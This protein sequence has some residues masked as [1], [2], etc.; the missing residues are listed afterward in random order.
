MT[1]NKKGDFLKSSLMLV[2]IFMTTTMIAQPS[3]AKPKILSKVKAET[4]TELMING[5]WR[6]P[7]TGL[8]WMRCSLGQTW[9]KKN[10]SCAGY[11]SSYV[12]ASDADAAANRLIFSGHD[13]WRLP[14]IIELS[15]V[16]KCPLGVVDDNSVNPINVSGITIYRSCKDY[17]WLDSKDYKAALDRSVFLDNDFSKLNEGFK[18]WYWSSSDNSVSADINANSVFAMHISGPIDWME[19]IGSRTI[20]IALVVRDG[21]A[22]ALDRM[23]SKEIEQSLNESNS[24]ARTV[25]NGFYVGQVRQTRPRGS[26]GMIDKYIVRSINEENQR[27]TIE[28]V[29]GTQGYSIDYKEIKEKLCSDVNDW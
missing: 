27:V 12:S 1:I 16:R 24:R 4:D 17:G 15:S 8:I 9:D 20:N 6:N 23:K 22:S 26:W 10:K 29:S 11:R 25:C 3:A 2:A 5:Q 19:R 28:G 18:V 14:T 7:E 21:S 13:D